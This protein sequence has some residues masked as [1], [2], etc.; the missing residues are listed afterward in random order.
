MIGRGKTKTNHIGRE[1]LKPSENIVGKKGSHI[2]MRL[3]GNVHMRTIRFGVDDGTKRQQTKRGNNNGTRA[4]SS[5]EAILM[6]SPY[7]QFWLFPALLK[8]PS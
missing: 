2:A 8:G 7:R 5:R 1:G 4:S 6:A 3:L